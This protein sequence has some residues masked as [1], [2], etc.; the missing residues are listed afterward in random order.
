MAEYVVAMIVYV[1]AFFAAL[2][3]GWQVCRAIVWQPDNPVY[4]A[5]SWARDNGPLVV[6]AGLLAGWLAITHGFLRR[7]L[8]YLDDVVGAAEHLAG[9]ADAPVSLPP[10]L[11]E[12]E[13]Q[14]NLVREQS[15]RAE[16]EAREAQ[17]R[18]DELLVYLAHDLK[19]PLTSVIGY[20]NLLADAPD[21]PAA[22]RARY[23]GIA[24]DKALR[25]EDL[26]NEFFEITR[27]NLSHLELETRAVDLTRMLEQV[28][29]EFA[30]A[31]ADRGMRCD[32]RLPARMTYVCDPDKM[33]R[34]FD[35]LLRNAC[36][37]GD[38]GTAVEV[39]GAM[40]AEGV[41]LT[42]VNHGRTIPPEKLERLFDRFYRLDSARG[43]GAGGAG[44]GL[45]IAREI[46]E[47]HGGTV[48]A[49]SADGRVAFRVRLPAQPC[50]PGKAEE[51][52]ALCAGEESPV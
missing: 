10:A 38:A 2:F 27:F 40:D 30:P 43:T 13:D 44:L 49:E 26:L 47:A 3:A 18:K 14:L 29:D 33:A 21:L 34:V 5:L 48:T 28:A 7:P 24:L 20:L 31:L 52:G 15:L 1:A 50:P 45:A 46:V 39:E 8:K 32:L 25:L 51:A 12:I 41:A 4:W 42:F 17:R 35:N 11:R 9:R 16:M 37:Y 19:T 36:S 23:T 22:Q 6:A